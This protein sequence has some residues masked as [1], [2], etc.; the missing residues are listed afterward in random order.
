MKVF[1][2]E[3]KITVF[4]G[5]TI[6]KTLTFVTEILPNGI[7]SWKIWRWKFTRDWFNLLLNQG[8]RNQNQAEGEDIGYHSPLVAIQVD[9][10]KKDKID[11]MGQLVH[12]ECRAYYR[13]VKHDK[14][15]KLGLVQFEVQ[16]L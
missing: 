5:S 11:Y 10:G 13:G 4:R 2:R 16:V 14:K 3:K 7:S 6:I 8:Q 12:M 1:T 15:D 9:L